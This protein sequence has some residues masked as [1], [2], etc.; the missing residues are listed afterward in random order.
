MPVAAL[1]LTRLTFRHDK[2]TTLHDVSL[3]VHPREC[4]AVLG[5]AGSGKTTL[6]RIVSGFATAA[7]GLVTHDGLLI[8]GAPPHRRGFGIVQQPDALFGHLTLAENVAYPLRLRGVRRRQ[9]ASLVETVL[10]LA[11]L[12]QSAG[13]PAREASPAE[14]QRAMLA[15]AAVF[16]PRILLLDDPFGMQD[17]AG[18]ALMRTAIRRIHFMLGSATLLATSEA[19][20]ALALADRVAVLDRGRL[21]QL[22]A[23]EELQER[24]GTARIASMLDETN[25]LDGAVTAIE[26]D[27]ATVKLACGPLAYA[28]SAASIYPDGR[29]VLAVD[30]SRIAVAPVAASDMGGWAL[31]AT[32]IETQ[33]MGDV[34]RLRLLLGSGAELIVRRPTGA[35]LR[36]LA[37]G[38]RVAVAWQPYHATAFPPER[39]R[40]PAASR[41]AWLP[42]G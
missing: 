9:R 42:A 37:P 18:R 27:I 20:E 3:A 35:G 31:D 26:D 22:A 6:M 36:G 23:P 40:E 32:L 12:S 28:R 11:H 14:R 29:C 33:F 13:L 38:R 5:P 25:L 7:E 1:E 39:P 8:A 4:V 30:P 41:Q 15:R 24:P 34:F 10:E 21:V 2:I 16:G 17:E 19:S